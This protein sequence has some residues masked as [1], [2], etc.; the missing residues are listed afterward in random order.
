MTTI[1]PCSKSRPQ[2]PGLR[3]VSFDTLGRSCPGAMQSLCEATHAAFPEPGPQRSA[4]LANVYRQLS[5]V[6]C[7]YLSRLL[8]ASAGR[9][10]ARTGSGWIKGAPPP[11]PEGLHK[12]FGRGRGCSQLCLCRTCVL[13]P[14]CPLYTGIIP[15]HYYASSKCNVVLDSW[16]SLCSAVGLRYCWLPCFRLI[17][18]PA[19]SM[20]SL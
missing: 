8:T 19:L 18:I 7:R 14:F 2:L 12:A 10:T 16:A 4:C 11:S 15:A 3:V 5:V 9:H 6:K 13:A 1:K 20:F 17:F